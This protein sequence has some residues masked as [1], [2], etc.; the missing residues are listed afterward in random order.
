MTDA[1][2]TGR[3]SALWSAVLSEMP[4]PAIG[5]SGGCDIWL[6]LRSLPRE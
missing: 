5:S 6:L 3:G 1:S 4:S 2:M